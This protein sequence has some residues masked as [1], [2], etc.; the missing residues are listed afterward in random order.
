MD[1]LTALRLQIEWG[2]DEALADQPIGL[3]NRPAPSRSP[4]PVPAPIPTVERPREVTFAR[5]GTPFSRALQAAE[6]AQSL[7]SL[8][9]ALVAAEGCALKD[10]AMNLVFVDGNPDAGLMLVG[11]APGPDDDRQGRPFAGEVGA[12][13]DRMLGSI[14]LDRTRAL[15]TTLLPWRPPGDR[16]PTESEIAFC[17]PFLL[18][19]MALVRP[20]HLLLMGALTAKVLLGDARPRGRVGGKPSWAEAAIPELGPVPALAMPSPGDAMRSPAA[21]REAWA[22]LRMLHRAMNAGALTS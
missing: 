7:E 3:L 2:A 11:D 22:V 12:Y 6:A 10:T 5:P 15:L 14:G 19:Q 13:L 18:R 1:A 17:R 8:R 4:Q 20:R 16:R 9:A 21:R